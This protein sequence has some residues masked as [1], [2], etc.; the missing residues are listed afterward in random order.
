MKYK[1]RYTNTPSLLQ[2]DIPDGEEICYIHEQRM[3]CDF[4][5][6]M[7]ASGKARSERFGCWI[8]L[9]PEAHRWLHD[10]PAGV[11]YQQELKAKCQIEFEKDHSREEWMELF[12]K[13]YRKDEE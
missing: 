1:Y 13:N 7:N 5:H 4:H 8:W 6:I 12:H 9:S 11:R 2:G 10:T 3:H